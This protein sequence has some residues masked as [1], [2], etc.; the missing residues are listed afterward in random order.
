MAKKFTEA[1][2]S[3]AQAA[4][5]TYA[6]MQGTIPVHLVTCKFDLQ[7]ESPTHSVCTCTAGGTSRLLE[8]NL[9]QS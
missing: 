5:C 6:R 8:D 7:I 3:N 4:Q 2:S 9:F 1:I